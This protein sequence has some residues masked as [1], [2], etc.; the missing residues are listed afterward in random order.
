MR[1]TQLYLDDR[2]WSALH[3]RARLQQTTISELVRQA[4]RDCYVPEADERR[5]AM[6]AL[7]GIRGRAPARPGALQTVRGLRRG[8][9]IER[10]AAK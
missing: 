5:K 8:S 7:V 3:A 9:R 2:L 10:L 1:R 4:V 6:E